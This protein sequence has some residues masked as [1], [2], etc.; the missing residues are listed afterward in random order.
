MTTRHCNHGCGAATFTD[1]CEACRTRTH[2]DRTDDEPRAVR[3][4]DPSDLDAAED[5]Q[6]RRL[7]AL[8]Y[9]RQALDLLRKAADIAPP[10]AQAQIDAAGRAA[11]KAALDLD[12]YASRAAD[13]IDLLRRQVAA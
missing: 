10:E 7:A 3:S 9:A 6:Q 2:L 8:A 5:R 13:G 12:W 4:V 1:S 11:E